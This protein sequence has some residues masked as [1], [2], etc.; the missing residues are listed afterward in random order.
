MLSV[1]GLSFSPLARRQPMQKTQSVLLNPAQDQVQFSGLFKNRA[2]LGSVLDGQPGARFVT[3]NRYPVHQSLNWAAQVEDIVSDVKQDLDS[4][5]IVTGK[6]II[7]SLAN[8][9]HQVMVGTS[10]LSGKEHWGI[11]RDK[12]DMLPVYHWVPECRSVFREQAKPKTD[13]DM[14]F[15]KFQSTAKENELPY[16]LVENSRFALSDQVVDYAIDLHGKPISL[17]KL[18][19]AEN[20]NGR[21]AL[22]LLMSPPTPEIKQHLAQQVDAI[23]QLRHQPQNSETLQEAVEKV[24]ALH[25]TFSLTMPY[26]QGSAGIAD[27]LS[28]VLFDE[29][30]IETGNWKRGISPDLEAFARPNKQAYMKSYS[31]FFETPPRYQ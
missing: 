1:S 19:Y 31:G 21:L 23:L 25:W 20:P 26:R 13:A 24:A 17:A 8:R 9:Y 28:K 6:A 2:V 12:L 4:D 16:R 7:E 29:L 30:G 5:K 15:F 18:Q 10:Q 27:M 3:T 14:P 22:Y 11:E